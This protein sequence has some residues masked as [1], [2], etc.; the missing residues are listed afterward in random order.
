LALQE[1]L[2]MDHEE[3]FRIQKERIQVVSQGLAGLS[4]VKAEELWERQ[5]P[6]MRLR[7]TLDEAALGKTAASVGQALKEGNP[8]IWVRV[9]G[10]NIFATVHA[11]NEGEEKIVA[12]RLRDLLS[13]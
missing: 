6:W 12:E 11:L 7:I 9:E 10:N 8:S 13:R 4:H 3:R 1:W 5:G 2:T